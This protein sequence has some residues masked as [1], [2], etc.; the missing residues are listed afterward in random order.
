MRVLLDTHIWL[1]VTLEP[2]KLTS[3]VDNVLG[4]PRNTRFLSPVS[5]WEAILLLEKKK[6]EIDK[7][8]AEWVEDS[9]KDLDLQEAA[10]NW[11]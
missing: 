1:W 8:F 4:D 6:I 3:A 11:K 10:F 5:I 7:D 2:H 9:R